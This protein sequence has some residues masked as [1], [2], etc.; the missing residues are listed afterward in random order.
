MHILMLKNRLV[1]APWWNIFVIETLFNFSS[2]I[3]FSALQQHLIITFLS[4]TQ[5]TTVITETLTTF[6]LLAI[7]FMMPTF[8]YL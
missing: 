5:Q 7:H 1:G 6:H 2:N 8:F 3:C 4:P